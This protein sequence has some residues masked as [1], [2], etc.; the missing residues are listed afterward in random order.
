MKKILM[1]AYHYPPVGA[2]SGVHRTLKFSQYLPE[3]C[4]E[5]T[6][7]TAAHHM[8]ETTNSCQLDDIPD[9]ICIR[10]AWG[11]DAARHLSIAGHYLG[12]SALPDRWSTWWL[13]GVFAGWRLVKSVRPN[14]I[15]STYPIATAHLIGLTLQRLTGLP[16]VAD[17]RDSMVD[18]V[19]P[20][21][22]YKRRLY[23]AIEKRVVHIATKVVFS[24]AGAKRMYAMRYPKLPESHWV[25]IA[26]GYDE[27]DFAQFLEPIQIQQPMNKLRLLH[28]GLLYP[29]ERDPR[30]FFSA[31]AALKKANV[32]SGENL[33][34]ILRAAGHMEQFQA[35]V[36][37]FNIADIVFLKSPLGYKAAIR[38]MAS[39]DGLL[40]FQSANCN[41][42]IP[43][44]LYEY[45][46]AGRPI[47]AMTDLEGDTAALLRDA[48]CGT[49]V[50]LN[51]SDAI[52][53]GLTRFIN[54]IWSGTAPVASEKTIKLHSRHS[55]TAELAEVLNNL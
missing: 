11:L 13:G 3:F 48:E 24:T 18:E 27:Q 14:V 19:F 22:G 21:Q 39:V 38:E 35:M 7:L 51:D 47:F 44:K 46:R 34:I 1:V 37:S 5:P 26:N 23:L 42:Q 12:L 50:P 6:I 36:M 41:H 55:R 33:E 9:D 16:W 40:I 29:L 28:S 10:R 30:S 17:F 53:L 54:Q 49:P 52:Q 31:V 2:S 4:W 20:Y 15:W 32:V 43:A 8:Y 45:L 25:V